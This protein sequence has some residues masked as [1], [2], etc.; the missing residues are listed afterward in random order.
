MSAS[1]SRTRA[2][3]EA[4]SKEKYHALMR[5]LRVEIAMVDHIL[6]QAEDRQ[7]TPSALDHGVISKRLSQAAACAQELETL[8]KGTEA[9]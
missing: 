4:R 2:V 5:D 1:Y 7:R 6:T 9:A 8:A 3:A